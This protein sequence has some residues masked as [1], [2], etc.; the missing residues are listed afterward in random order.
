MPDCIVMVNELEFDD[1]ESLY[2]LYKQDPEAYR[3]LLQ[4]H[5]DMPHEIWS[6]TQPGGNAGAHAAAHIS[7]L[8]SQA[9]GIRAL[10][11]DVRAACSS[12]K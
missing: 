8:R 11:A 2:A 12:W 4:K 10:A 5:N 1:N 3:Q 9:E 6:S 7:E